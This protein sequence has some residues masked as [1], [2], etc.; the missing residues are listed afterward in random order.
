[1]FGYEIE[2]V[3]FNLPI[4]RDIF[5]GVYSSNTLPNISKCLFPCA[6]IANTEKDID[7]G[8]HWVAFYFDKKNSSKPEYFDSYGLL[9]LKQNF[10]KFM[11]KP[12]IYS[13]HLIQNPFSSTCGYYS[14][15]FIIK[16]CEGYTYQK[17]ISSFT[18]DTTLNDT[19]V[20]KYFENLNFT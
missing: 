11:K 19:I 14:M 18:T 4:T 10:V 17:I 3:L 15:Y 7:Q 1:M 6:Y 13:T 16:R 9:P 8:E 20:T 12:F 2:E 5:Q